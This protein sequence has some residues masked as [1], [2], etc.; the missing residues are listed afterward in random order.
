MFKDEDVEVQYGSLVQLT[1]ALEE[2]SLV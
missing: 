1:T 2:G